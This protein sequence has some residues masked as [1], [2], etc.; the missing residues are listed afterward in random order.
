MHRAPSVEPTPHPFFGSLP[1]RTAIQGIL[2]DV[3]LAVCFV[4][5]GALSSGDVDW[6]LLLILL[7]KT[8]LMTLASSIMKRVKPLP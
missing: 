3:I 8:A 4:L 1:W 5:Y 6:Y 7:G 2:I